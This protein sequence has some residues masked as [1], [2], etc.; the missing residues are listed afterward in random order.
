M[1]PTEEQS[2]ILTAATSTTD[3]LIIN[4]L[5]GCG[6][7]S[8]LELIEKAVSTRPI[9]Y[10][11][12]NTKNAKE[13][14]KR[15]LS[16]TSVRTLN[17]LGHRIWA[18]TVGRNLKVLPSKCGDILR[19]I[20]SE[21]PRDTRGE[22]WASYPAI[23]DGV[24]M[25]KALGYLPPGTFTQAR[26]L[27]TREAL[28]AK[29]DEKPDELTSAL[30]DQVL[31]TSTKAAYEGTIDYNDQIYMPALFGGTFPT[32][33][34][35]L[36]DESQDL[37]PTNHAILRRLRGRNT[38]TIIVGDRF[39]S[40][41]G[42]RGACEGGM[43]TLSKEYN[44]SPFDLSV[45]FRCPSAIV[46][47]ARWRAPHFRWLKEGGHVETLKELDLNSIPDGST[48]IC[49]NNAPLFRLAMRLLSAGR[50]VSVAGSDIGPKLIR[51]M[52]KFGE[53]DLSRSGVLAAIDS[54]RIAKEAKGSK[55]AP[56]IAE[57]MKVF[58]DHGGNLVQAIAYAEHLF[59][60]SGSIA[61]MTGHK[62]KGLE[63]PIVY[64]L[65]P[66]LIGEEDQ[67]LN[68]RYVTQTR[69]LDQYYEIDSAAIC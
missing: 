32:F 60:Q 33:P 49:R 44:A 48:F 24:A 1:T 68:L 54:W 8:T 5:A 61:L 43:G 15:M 29:L 12:F 19:S 41:Y 51:I 69:S 65:D 20:I 55:A 22:L 34:L 57:A 9:L 42:F 2:A 53:D 64:H 38:R 25:A 13:A 63:F 10:L 50:S 46:A 52:R 18:R 58:A 30:I 21:A 11:V 23:L 14:E 56:D 39:Q 67:E 31:T 45:S 17:S 37:S 16:T 4:S 47:N 27:C 40:I 35:L 3:N 7:T 59:K 26:S 6:K 28:H 66:W 62:S 36:V